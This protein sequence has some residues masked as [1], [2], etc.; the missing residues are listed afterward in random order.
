MTM[1]AAVLTNAM[2]A[3]T[4]STCARRAERQA[5]AEFRSALRDA[6]S[7]QAEDA[8]QRERQ[9][10]GGEDAKQYGEESLAAVLCVALKGFI[11]GKVP[12]KLL[13]ESSGRERRMR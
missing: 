1:P 12:L 3:A 4:H 6:V 7:D 11:Q 10:H 8:D 2:R 13:L 5:D 9:R